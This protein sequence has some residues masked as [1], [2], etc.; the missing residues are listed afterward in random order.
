MGCVPSV[1]FFA[2]TIVCNAS[3]Q[4][5]KTAGRMEHPAN[6]LVMR[7]WSLKTIAIVGGQHGQQQANP[8]SVTET[9]KIRSP[10]DE[11]ETQ[12]CLPVNERGD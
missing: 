4:R 1:M 9:K 2:G 11:K 6:A 5:Q 7:S 8:Y 3:G 10:V 12:A